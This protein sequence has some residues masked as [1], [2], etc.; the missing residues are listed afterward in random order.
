MMMEGSFLSGNKRA[1]KI[2]KLSSPIDFSPKEKDMSHFSVEILCQE[3]YNLST[4]R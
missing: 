1:W 3:A 2:L 4:N